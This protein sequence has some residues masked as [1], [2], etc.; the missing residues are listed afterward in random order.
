MNVT[1]HFSERAFIIDMLKRV[2]KYEVDERIF[3]GPLD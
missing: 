2:S 3:D 1:P